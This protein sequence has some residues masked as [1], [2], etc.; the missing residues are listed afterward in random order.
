LDSATTFME[1][2]NRAGSANDNMRT[3]HAGLRVD[4]VVAGGASEGEAFL[5]EDPDECLIRDRDNL[6]H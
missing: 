2:I 4:V 1:R 5:L 3:F 6:R